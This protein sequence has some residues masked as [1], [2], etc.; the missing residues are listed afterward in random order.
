MSINRMID[1]KTVIGL[2]NGEVFYGYVQSALLPHL[3]PFN[4]INPNSI[5]VLDNCTKIVEMIE[6]LGMFLP[7]Y[8]P[9]SNPIEEAFSKVLS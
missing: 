9:D 7:P 8:S 6:I 2:V 1:C 5:V 3:M 4:G